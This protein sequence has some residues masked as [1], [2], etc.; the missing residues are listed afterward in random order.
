MAALF[1]FTTDEANAVLRALKTVAM[2]DG[3]FAIKE[4]A[5]LSA[6]AELLG[7]D[8]G[9]DAATTLA[10][11]ELAAA[12]VDPERRLMA[13]KACLVM[14]IVDGQVSPEEW[15]VL[16]AFRTALGIEENALQVFHGLV[17]G[18]RQRTQYELQRRLGSPQAGT[19]YAAQGWQG[20]LNFFT[21]DL[22]ALPKTRENSE[23]AWR[24]RRIG[25]L[26]EG[27]LGRELWRYYRERQ[28][29]FAG[30][31]GGVPEALVHHDIT[32]ILAGYDGDL[33]GELETLA[34]IAGLRGEDPA[35]AL[36]LVLLQHAVGVR[37]GDTDGL[38]FVPERILAAQE[39]GRA[40]GEDFT[41][42]HDFWDVMDRP[43]S[44]LLQ[45]FGVPP[46]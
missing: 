45:R 36:F 10:P 14:G 19:L 16:S 32:H 11:E 33:Q 44:E 15:R 46:R 20:V 3:M 5:L 12:V 25:L 39:R 30:E 29:A 28:F 1:P 24:Y 6:S 27:T 8:G 9:P 13:L 23:L 7:V 37:V 42:R 31:L 18:H 34:F 40:T 26:P 21:E 4:Q 38:S 43:I 35:S 17:Q 2:A 22:L 41:R